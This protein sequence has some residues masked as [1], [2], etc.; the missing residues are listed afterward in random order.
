MTAIS[1]LICF[2]LVVLAGWLF[3]GFDVP[4]RFATARAAHRIARGRRRG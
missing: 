1:W 2:A 3:L 4:D